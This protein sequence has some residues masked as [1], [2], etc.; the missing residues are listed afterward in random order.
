MR[1]VITHQDRQVAP[2]PGATATATGPRTLAGEHELLLQQVTLRADAVLATL[3]HRWPRAELAALVGYLRTEVLRQ[4]ADEEWL[5]FPA[6]P[7]DAG[8]ARL[9]DDHVRLRRLVDLLAGAAA[10]GPDWRPA[11]L[12]ATVRDLVAQLKRHLEVE[13]SLVAGAGT[14]HPATATALLTGRRHQW[15]ALT[16]GPVV[17]VDALPA[18][19]AIAALS[20]RLLRLPVG[21]R[22]ELRSGSDLGWVWR[23]LDRLDPGGFGFRYLR[24]GP[25]RWAMQV[26]RRRRN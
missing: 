18:D 26:T 24:E 15:Y 19:H 6:G 20:E 13:E 25:D 23:R 9:G 7:A 8:F 14:P 22:I 2:Q 11:R 12:V 1:F 21:D 10:G 3:P 5:L 16:E 17:D 4:A